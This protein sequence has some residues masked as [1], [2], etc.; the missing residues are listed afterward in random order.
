MIQFA[1]LVVV[2]D[3]P[4]NQHDAWHTGRFE[5]SRYFLNRR[6]PISQQA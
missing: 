1:R 4:C 5:R 6:G 3:W 2:D